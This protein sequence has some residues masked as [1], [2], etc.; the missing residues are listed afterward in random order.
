LK[1]DI[2]AIELKLVAF[3]QL[4]SLL[5]IKPAFW[6]SASSASVKVLSA[7]INVSSVYSLTRPKVVVVEYI[8]QGSYVD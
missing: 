7:T 6:S 5:A 8:R 2:P 3:G 4:L 1:G